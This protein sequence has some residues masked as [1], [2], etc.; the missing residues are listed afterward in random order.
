MVALM[1]DFVNFDLSS[2]EYLKLVFERHCNTLALGEKI[3]INDSVKGE[4]EL[5]SYAELMSKFPQ[6]DNA[7]KDEMKVKYHLN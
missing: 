1:N 4:H 7:F 2:P 6:L 5:S 3:T